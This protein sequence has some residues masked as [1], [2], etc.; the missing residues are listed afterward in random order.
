MSLYAITSEMQGILDSLDP[1]SE[2]VIAYLDAHWL[3]AIPTREELEILINW[4]GEWIAVV[5]DFFIPDQ[6]GYGF[7]QY[8]D[9][10]IGITQIPSGSGLEVYVPS[11]SSTYE[12]GARRGTGYILSS[13]LRRSLP[14]EVFTHLRLIS[15]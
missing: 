9:V 15:S 7:D 10:V 11:E 2:K 13:Q 3:D 12:T 1:L 8:K 4:G 14:E 6:P 5:D